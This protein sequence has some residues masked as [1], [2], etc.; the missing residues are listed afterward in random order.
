[1]MEAFENRVHKLAIL[2]LGFDWPLPP[3]S[4]GKYSADSNSGFTTNVFDISRTKQKA[5]F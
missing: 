2:V 5:V 4:V 1:M 3:G